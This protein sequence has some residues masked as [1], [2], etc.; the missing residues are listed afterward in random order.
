VNEI[1]KMQKYVG[2]H[3]VPYNPR[4]AMSV[5]ET[6]AILDES[7]SFEMINLAFTYGAAKGYQQAKAEARKAGK[8]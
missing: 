1:E 6:R 5:A 2:K 7:R 4:Y 8:V 3:K